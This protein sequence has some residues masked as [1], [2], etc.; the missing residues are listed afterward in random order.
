MKSKT[1]TTYNL[2]L[3]PRPFLAIK[4]GTKRVEYRTNTSNTPYD[5]GKI[6]PADLI[7]FRLQ[8]SPEQITCK[9][10]RVSHYPNA[11][12]MYL[13]EGLAN[14]SS[15]PASIEEAVERIE[16]LTGYKVAIK[17][18]GIWAIEFEVLLL[19]T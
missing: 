14:S 3:P 13:T 19:K 8:E 1:H 4:H 5:Y 18:H 6:R 12:Q 11:Q 15:I 10:V 16:A 7:E 2:S 9:V 17:Q